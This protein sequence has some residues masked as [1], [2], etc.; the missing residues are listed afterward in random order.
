MNL[1]SEITSTSSFDNTTAMLENLLGLEE[2]YLIQHSYFTAKAKISKQMRTKLVTWMLEVCEETKL[3]DDI[4]SLSVNL[5]DRLLHAMIVKT[6]FQ[7]EVSHLQ[8][9][10]IVCLFIA[11]KLKTKAHILTSLRLIEYTD[12]SVRLDELL[13]WELLVLDKLRWDIAA[14]VPNDYLEIFF[15]KLPYLSNNVE[16]TK[17]VR[18]H[19]DAFTALCSLDF[20]FSFY[21]PSMLASACLLTAVNGLIKNNVLRQHPR[22]GQ[23][24]FLLVNHL[25]LDLAN[26]INCDIDSLLQVKEQVDSLYM[27]NI[28]NAAEPGSNSNNPVNSNNCE[29]VPEL[30]NNSNHVFEDDYD[31]D[32]DYNLDCLSLELNNEY[33]LTSLNASSSAS[34]DSNNTNNDTSNSS[35]STSILNSFAMYSPFMFEHNEQLISNKLDANL[36]IESANKKPKSAKKKNRGISGGKLVGKSS[37]RHLSYNRHGSERAIGFSRSSSSS[38]GISSIASNTN[39]ANS[40]SLLT[41]PMANLVPLPSF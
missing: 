3:T 32:L 38:S 35:S 8:L 26:F 20:K 21:P 30:P 2:Y 10:G 4:F 40:C 13:E 12:N 7:V 36:I 28:T 27:S 22:D 25:A 39:Y 23:H 9:F 11:A 41:P 1:K 18:K 31:F 33:L 6:Q 16:Q 29:P 5:L 37:S 14:I 24:N 19:F 15:N 17:L 34:N